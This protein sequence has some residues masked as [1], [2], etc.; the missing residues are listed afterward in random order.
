MQ[1]GNQVKSTPL[2]TV[3]IPCFNQGDFIEECINSVLN[4]SYQSIEIIC[5]DDASTDN[6]R[7]RIRKYTELPNF[8]FIANSHNLG[9][10]ASRNNAIHEANGLY[11]LPLD[12]DDTIE[13]TYIDEAVS[14]ISSNEDIG[15]VYCKARFFG[16]INRNWDLPDFNLDDFLFDNC[17]FCSALFRKSDFLKVGGYKPYMVYGLEDYELW[18]S[19]I[20]LGLKPY[21]ID[22]IL[23][24]YR[25]KHQMSRTYKL[26]SSSK[27]R[28]MKKEIITHHLQ[29]YLNNESF[30]KYIT[31]LCPRYPKY[32]EK[33]L[34]ENLKKTKKIKK[35]K[36]LLLVSY[37]IFGCLFVIM[38]FLL[39]N[40][41]C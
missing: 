33:L 38:C 9:V 13:P 18:M 17:I 39:K 30:V 34:N 26:V 7:E 41:N 22:R 36:K 3:V 21:R 40:A 32:I 29:L 12:G 6:S 14:V 15:I 24:N 37:F 10:C 23:F 8:K 5:V 2:V 11:I 31:E 16:G 35:Y 20:E 27:L 19:F 1:N 25:R 4:Q 28:D